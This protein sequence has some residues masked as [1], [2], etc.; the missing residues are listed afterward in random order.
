MDI[1]DA[2]SRE[3]CTV[4]RDRTNTPLQALVVL[5]DPQFIEA[6]RALADDAILGG[7]N[8]DQRFDYIATRLLSRPLAKLK[9]YC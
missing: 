4:R 8:D 1:L 6:S 9:A 3:V 5:N 7:S 2:P